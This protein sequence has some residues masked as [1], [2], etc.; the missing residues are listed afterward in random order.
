M[1]GKSGRVVNYLIFQHG[2]DR[3]LGGTGLSFKSAS[4]AVTGY[5][6]AQD[7]WG[8]GFAT[9]ALQA[10]VEVARLAGVKQLEA[11]AIS[12]CAFSACT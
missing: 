11:S 12:P 5:V 2:E 7:A 1:N 10:M 9:E 8:Q 6:F 3:L 4:V